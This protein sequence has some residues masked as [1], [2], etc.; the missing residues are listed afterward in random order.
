MTACR[1]HWRINGQRQQLYVPWSAFS[2]GKSHAERVAQRLQ[3]HIA[4][5]TSRRLD[6][7]FW[8]QKNKFIAEEVAAE[9][10]RKHGA[11]N[12]C[13]K[14]SEADDDGSD[15]HPVARAGTQ[16]HDG[17][18]TQLVDAA[19]RMRAQSVHPD[20]PPRNNQTVADA[21]AMSAE[22]AS[23]C[24]GLHLH[25]AAVLQWTPTSFS[26]FPAV[27]FLRSFSC[28]NSRERKPRC[29]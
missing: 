27:V 9:P 29:C 3:S 1:V 22:A 7:E 21:H 19:K 8:E 2:G 26:R 24:D 10:A 13:A 11:L 14:E 23:S 17:A 28:D 18:Y 12:K 15:S 20:A 6:H 4:S 16:Q 25:F 5:T